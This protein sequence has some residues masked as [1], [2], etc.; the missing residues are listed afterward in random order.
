MSTLGGLHEYIR[1]D[2]PYAVYTWGDL[3]P[4]VWGGQVQG[5]KLLMGDS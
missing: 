4:P 1:Q 5:E 2:F 3:S